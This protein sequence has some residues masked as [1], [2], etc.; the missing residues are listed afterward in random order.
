[1]IVRAQPQEQSTE[2]DGAE[3]TQEVLSRIGLSGKSRNADSQINPYP[4]PDKLRV[5]ICLVGAARDFELTGPSIMYR[6]L[7]AYPG[8]HL[9]VNSPL[10]EAS[11]KLHALAWASANVTV[12]GMRVFPNSWVDETQYP[13]GVIMDPTSPQGTQVWRRKEVST[14]RFIQTE[15]GVQQGQRV[16]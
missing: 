14:F 4:S 15:T 10:D 8:S 2:A 3:L 11:F 1:M 13:E 16:Y 12:A 7:T 9:F 6:V 5:A